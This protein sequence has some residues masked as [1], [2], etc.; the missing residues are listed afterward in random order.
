MS[1]E[2]NLWTPVADE[3]DV[4]MEGIDEMM[5]RVQILCFDL[6]YLLTFSDG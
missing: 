4:T 1:I 2:E 5:D 6:S 3:Q